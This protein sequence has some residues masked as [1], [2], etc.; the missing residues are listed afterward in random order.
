VLTLSRPTSSRRHGLSA[1]EA[2][3]EAHDRMNDRRYGKLLPRYAGAVAQ[4]L[5]AQ[6]DASRADLTDFI[7]TDARS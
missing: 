3:C 5:F 6:P 2:I 1:K 4:F 7:D